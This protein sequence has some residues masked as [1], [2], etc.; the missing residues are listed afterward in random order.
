MPYEMKMLNVFRL[1]SG[2][3]STH[4]LF[5]ANKLE[6]FIIM[7]LTLKSSIVYGHTDIWKHGD[8]GLNEKTVSEFARKECEKI[9]INLPC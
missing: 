7:S 6:R 3:V 4:G 8:H 5:E 2:V 9:A 1:L